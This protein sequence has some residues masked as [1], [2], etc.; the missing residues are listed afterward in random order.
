MNDFGKAVRTAFFTALNQA[1]TSPEGGGGFIPVVDQKLDEQITE[2]DLYILIGAQNETPGA[3]K[4]VWAK[5][6]D[7]TVT[8]CNRR[9]STNSKV[10][11][12]DIASQISTIL[13]P[14]RTS[15]GITLA[16]PFKLSYVKE[17]NA[18]YEFFKLESG[19]QVTKQTTF[20]TRLTQ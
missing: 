10:L 12:E 5:E 4:T 2:H 3:V 17:T 8:I 15:F 9:K 13:F 11:V 18:E 6:V 19:W 1:V 16:A 20:K 7:L 14:S